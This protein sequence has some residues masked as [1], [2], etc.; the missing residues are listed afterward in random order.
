MQ[1]KQAPD[2]E[3]GT[4]YRRWPVDTINIGT[5]SIDLNPPKPESVVRNLR[6]IPADAEERRIEFQNALSRF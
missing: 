5:I 1:K 6:T 2:L 3:A 4:C